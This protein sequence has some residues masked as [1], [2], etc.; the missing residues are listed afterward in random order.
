V[1]EVLSRNAR[2]I[3]P[4]LQLIIQLDLRGDGV[5]GNGL[6]WPDGIY[7][8]GVNTFFLDKAPD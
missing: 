5:G 3:R 8:D 1:R 6:S 2:R 4:I 7:H